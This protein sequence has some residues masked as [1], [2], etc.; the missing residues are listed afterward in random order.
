MW[1]VRRH[2]LLVSFMDDAG[3]LKYDNDVIIVMK[4]SDNYSV[5]S[6]KTDWHV[7]CQGSE[8]HLTL[9]V[10]MHLTDITVIINGY[11][12]NNYK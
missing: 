2:W 3:A 5:I 12:A 7:P 8:G 9:S 10:T 11:R 4:E 1:G 6:N